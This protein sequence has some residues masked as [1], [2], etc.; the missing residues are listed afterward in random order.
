MQT[1]FWHDYILHIPDYPK[2]GVD[3]KDITPLIADAAAYQQVID[4]MADYCT[5]NNLQPDQLVCPEARGFMFAPALAYRL[6]V[7]FLPLRKPGKLPRQTAFTHYELEY[8]TDELHIHRD[9][10]VAGK[11]IVIVDDVLA[12]GGTVAASVALLQ[13]LGANVVACLF[14]MSIDALGGQQRIQ[15]QHPNTIVHALKHY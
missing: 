4:A 8:G 13:S 14:V 10:I 6:G 2:P 3:F 1:K 15:S 5:Q 12:T 9:D 7:G 11:R